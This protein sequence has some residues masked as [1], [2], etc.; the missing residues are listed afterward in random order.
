MSKVCSLTCLFISALNGV[1]DDGNEAI[2][3]PVPSVLKKTKNRLSHVVPAS[4]PAT[5]RSRGMLFLFLE[6]LFNHI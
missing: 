2:S 3:I 5:S 1:S 6:Q 4:Q